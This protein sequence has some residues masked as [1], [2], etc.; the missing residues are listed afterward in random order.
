MAEITRK[1]VKKG[2]IKMGKNYRRGMT[3]TCNF[4]REVVFEVRTILKVLEKT[5][6]GLKQ[7]KWKK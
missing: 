1:V 6:K 5:D 3:I 2:I 4:H 7:N